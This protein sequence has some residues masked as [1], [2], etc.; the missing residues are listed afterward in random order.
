MKET[1]ARY[2]FGTIAILAAALS[3]LGFPAATAAISF[4]GRDAPKLATF[5]YW[6]E[7]VLSPVALPVQGLST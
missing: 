2:S 3:S 7:A 6:M 4:L 5:V 1:G